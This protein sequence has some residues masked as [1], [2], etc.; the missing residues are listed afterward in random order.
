MSTNS[1]NQNS[2][3]IFDYLINFWHCW[4]DRVMTKINGRTLNNN[5]IKRIKPFD[6]FDCFDFLIGKLPMRPI[7]T[8][9][10]DT[11]KKDDMVIGHMAII[12]FPV[13]CKCRN[14][15]KEQRRLRSPAQLILF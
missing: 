12:P 3:N 8:K 2:L 15:L 9:V 4:G 7:S 11:L 14:V 6:C 10:N 1:K 5:I 13:L